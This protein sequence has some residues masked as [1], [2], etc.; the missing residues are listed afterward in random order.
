MLLLKFQPQLNVNY[1]HPWGARVTLVCF[2]WALASLLLFPA[3]DRELTVCRGD[4]WQ[5]GPNETQTAPSRHLSMGMNGGCHPLRH[6]RSV[7][8]LVC[9]SLQQAFEGCLLWGQQG[10]T[11]NGKASCTSACTTG[12]LSV[13]GCVCETPRCVKVRAF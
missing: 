7:A 5:P 2:S 11:L 6:T 4:V 10:E 1:L 12:E 9:G 13:R 8:V 3:D